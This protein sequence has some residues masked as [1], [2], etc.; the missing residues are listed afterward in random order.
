MMIVLP[1]QARDKLRHTQKTMAFFA[2]VW[3]QS[4]NFSDQAGG[5]YVE[6]DW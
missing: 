4:I 3:E 6:R 1:R 5:D 2:Q